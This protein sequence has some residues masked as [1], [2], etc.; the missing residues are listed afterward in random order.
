[1][2]AQSNATLALRAT[3][4]RLFVAFSC[5][6]PKPHDPSSKAQHRSSDADAGPLE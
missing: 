2:F 1:V 4:L 5:L 6:P 3:A